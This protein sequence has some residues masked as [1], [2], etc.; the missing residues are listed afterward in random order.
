MPGRREGLNLDG[1]GMK[2][3]SVLLPEALLE[4]VEELVR[5][6][7]YANRSEALRAAVRDLLKSEGVRT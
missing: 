7:R 5:K 6:G 4:G 1:R 2:V 3:V